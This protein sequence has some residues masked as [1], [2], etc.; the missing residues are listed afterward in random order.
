MYNTSKLNRVEVLSM[1]FSTA[2]LWS[3]KYWIVGVFL[4]MAMGLL[5]ILH[6]TVKGEVWTVIKILSKLLASVLMGVAM[7]LLGESFQVDQSGI[8]FMA[9]I[10]G[11]LGMQLLDIGRAFLENKAGI[12]NSKK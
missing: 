4:A 11:G 10:G 5:Q 3:Q 1:E 9:M 7:I 6:L 2:L 8:I 12:T